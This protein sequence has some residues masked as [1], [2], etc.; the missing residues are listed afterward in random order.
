MANN[1]EA[2][3]P[4]TDSFYLQPDIPVL[5]AYNTGNK[6]NTTTDLTH[7]TYRLNNP[8]P[9]KIPQE[10]E[11]ALK[12]NNNILLTMEMWEKP[13]IGLAD[14]DV[15]QS[16]LDGK[17]DEKLHALSAKIATSK[18]EVYLRWNP[19]MEVPVQLYPWQNQSPEVYIDAF[20]HVAMLCKKTAPNISIVW[21]AAGYPGTLEYWPGA[22]VVDVSSVTLQSE[23]ELLTT[24]YAKE[25]DTPTLIRRKLHRLRFTDKP[26]LILGSKQLGK[27]NFNKDWLQTAISRTATFQSAYPVA[28]SPTLETST[29]I[30]TTRKSE[31]QV[32]VYDP[33]KELV[34]QPEIT[35]EHLFA[36]WGSLQDGRFQKEFEAAVARKHEVIVTMEPWREKNM[37]KN[38]QVLQH[39]L[40]GK[41]DNELKQLYDIISNTDQTIYLRWAHEMEIPIT[42]YPWQSQDPET[43]IKAYRYVANF[44][45]KPAPNIRFVWG[46]AG[47]R[48]SL[49]WW[50]GD[51]VVDYISIAIYG[52]PD[53]NITDHNQQETFSTIFSRKYYRMRF[54][55]KPLFI[56]EFGVKGPEKYKKA[57]LEDAAQTININPQVKGVCYFNIHDSPKAWGE[58]QP[59]DWS[60]SPAT[61]QHFTNKLDQSQR[62]IT[63]KH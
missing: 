63:A 16:V 11:T 26:I 21:G 55:N 15:L 40:A 49:E 22:D 27:S 57:W 41:Y 24:A 43:Y 53:K 23:S 44:I 20:R 37:E 56:T 2:I 7:Y 28:T 1:I 52:L 36:D 6:L 17:Y 62:S 47:D 61:F 39:T 50:P 25:P 10:L 13:G 59:P 18:K 34:E 35:V 3:W 58:I 48:G 31:L 12:A 19:E 54:V 33:K 5:G 8:E 60:V 32:G 30:P 45:K 42:R 51:D 46:P 14:Y 38:P 29:Q 4:A 9:N